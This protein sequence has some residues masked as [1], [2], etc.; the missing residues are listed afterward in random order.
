MTARQKKWV[1]AAAVAALI[2]FLGIGAWQRFGREDRYEGLVS[3]NGRIEA[4]EI[5]VAPKT[6]GR[7]KDILVREGDLVKAGQVVAL[8]D[9]ESL[10]AQ[11]RQAQ[12]QLRQAVSNIRTA[13]SGLLQRESEREAARATVRQREA[14]LEVA[15]KRARRSAVLVEEGAASRQE[16]DDDLARVESARA[17]VSAAEAQLAAAEAAT[18]TARAS[19]NGARSVVE[20]SRATIERIESDIKDSHLRAPREG[21]V[22]YRTAQPGEVLA[23]GAPVLNLVDLSDVYMTFFLPTAAAG[24]VAIGAEV[25]LRLDA[26][27]RY[28]IPAYIS[29]ISDVAQFTPKTVETALERQKLMFRVRAQISPELLRRH[30]AYVKTGLPGV[31]FVKIDPDAA[32]PEDLRVNIR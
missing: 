22:Q 20:A 26:A 17:A 11:L 7:V 10:E 29:F 6:P 25:H 23:A 28:I 4:V 18:A 14:E 19:I 1:K 21:R 31:A 5:E 2:I 8:M 27:P 13:E 32:W 16:A 12:A 3:G 9:T 15:R 30:I 24:R